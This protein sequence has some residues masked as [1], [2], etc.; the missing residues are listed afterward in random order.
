M[1][2]CEGHF[3]AFLDVK[4]RHT[5]MHTRFV[6][7]RSS[8]AGNDMQF[9]VLLGD[10]N[11]VYILGK[12][13]LGQVE[14]SLYG[15]ISFNARQSANK[16][17]VILPQ[18]YT[19]SIFIRIHCHCFPIIISQPIMLFHGLT[20]R[21]HFNPVCFHGTVNRSI[22]HLNKSTH[23]LTGVIQHQTGFQH[24]ALCCRRQLGRVFLIGMLF[25]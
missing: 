8:T 1:Y 13:C 6:T 20:N 24:L 9:R 22:V 2:H 19:G 17:A 3:S 15:V 14:A 25:R 4:F 21:H 10:D 5:Q 18:F 23:S 7:E 11:I 12:F 16:V